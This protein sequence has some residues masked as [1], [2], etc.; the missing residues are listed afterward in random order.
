MASIAAESTRKAGGVSV[1]RR[2]VLPELALLWLRFP[3]AG[4]GIAQSNG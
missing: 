2:G 3:E 1:M 4:G